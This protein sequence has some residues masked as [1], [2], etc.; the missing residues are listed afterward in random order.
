MKRIFILL[1]VAFSAIAI[2]ND[3]LAQKKKKSKSS[4]DKKSE[5]KE[6][7]E[8]KKKLKETD[9]LKFRDMTQELNTLRGQASGL[10]AEIS[11]LEQEKEAFDSK[12]KEKDNEIA[13]L[14]A[15]LDKLKKKMDNNVSASGDDYTK[16]IVYKVQIGAFKNRDLSKFQDK[17]NF[18]MEDEDGLK[19]YTIAYFRD[20]G[21]ADQFKKYMR[22]MGVKD[23]WIVAYDDNVR[24]DIKDVK[25]KGAG[26]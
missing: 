10:K 26:K 13:D 14:R 6:I 22:A 4:N 1:L 12:L 20:Y 21:E 19:K 16:G 25:R 17:G 3:A 18:W 15:E 8:W 24:K 23:A 7:K 2:D 5:K 9:P 11:K